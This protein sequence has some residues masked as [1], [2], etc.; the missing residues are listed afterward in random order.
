[1]QDSST[2]LQTAIVCL[3]IGALLYAAYS[4]AR[5]LEIANGVSIFIALLFLPAAWNSSL[6]TTDMA[7][8]ASVGLGMLI[9][10]IALFACGLMGGGDAKLMAAVAVWTGIET[11]SV[12]LVV[13]ALAG[14]VVAVVALTLNRIPA[15]GTISRIF[16]WV[17]VGGGRQAPIPYGV[18]ISVAALFA[19]WISPILPDVLR[20]EWVS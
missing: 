1:M 2:A 9:A 13:T 3:Y 19:L 7:I 8:H 14:A 5:R 11:L 16:P 10:G 6:S 20:I 4:D 18:A 15:N 17:G 12:F